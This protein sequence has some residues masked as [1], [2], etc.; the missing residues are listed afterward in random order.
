MADAVRSYLDTLRQID[1]RSAVD[2]A[3]LTGSIWWLLLLVRGTTAMSLLRGAAIVL[4][5]AFALANVFDLTVLNWILRNSL[6]VLLLGILIIF[7]PE[8]RRVLERVG[9]TGMRAV[10][11]RGGYD[12]VIDIVTH[13]SSDLARR[14]HGA[15]IVLERD[16][17]LEEY[18]TTGRRLDAETSAELL[19]GIF[20]RNSPLHDGAAVI[21]G[22]RV[23]AA[24]CT[25]PLSETPL[26]K[27]YGTRHRAALGISERTDAVAVIVS[28]ETGDVSIAADGRFSSKLD[29][30]RLRETL[31][32]L[33]GPGQNGNGVPAPSRNG[34]KVQP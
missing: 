16:T 4:I 8:I 22:D 20:Y 9:R 18:I 10:R 1:A 34:S 33:V 2:I 26:P 15:L 11:G 19:E 32:L 21:R 17:G 30:D 27:Q 28:E 13:A 12:Q 31:R 24:A 5:G 25:L 29:E 14:R 3:L 7:Q 23:I 6:S